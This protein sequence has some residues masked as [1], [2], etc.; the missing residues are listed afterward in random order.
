MSWQVYTEKR[1]AIAIGSGKI[2]HVLRRMELLALL[3][4][5]SSP[6]WNG[7]LFTWCFQ[8]IFFGLGMNISTMFLILLSAMVRW[9]KDD[10]SFVEIQERSKHP[11]KIKW[12]NTIPVFGICLCI[13]DITTMLFIVLQGGEF[14]YHEWLFQ[15]S[16][17]ATWVGILIIMRYESRYILTQNWVL[18]IWWFIK[19]FLDLP[20]LWTVC[21]SS[22]GWLSICLKESCSIFIEVIFGIMI[23]ILRIRNFSAITENRESNFLKHPLIFSKG[24]DSKFSSHDARTSNILSYL[25]FSWVGPMMDVGLKRQLNFDDLFRLPDEL[26]PVS[27]HSALQSYWVD[28]ERKLVGEPSLFRAICH[29]YGWPYLWIGILKVLNDGLGFM[30]PLL[31]NTLIRILQGDIGNGHPY[32]YYCAFGLGVV[33]VS[34]AFLGSHYSYLLSKLKL[35][36][37]ASIITIVYQKCL[38]ISLAERTTFS[39]GEIQTLM[40]V[41]AD[42]AVNICASFHD[43]WSLPLQMGVA[44]FLLYMQVKFAFLAGLAVIILLIP[45]NR[46]IAGKISTASQ[47]M[48][49]QKDERV[50]KIGELLMYIRTLKMYNW[51]NIFAARLMETRENEVKHLATRKYLDAWCVYFWAT[52]PILFSLFTFGVYVLLGYSLD[53]A[54]VFTSLSLFNMLISPLNSFPWVINGLIE[55]FI[56]LQRLGRFLSCTELNSN[57]G[58]IGALQVKRGGI[59]PSGNHNEKIVEDMQDISIKNAEYVWSNSQQECQTPV[60][61][62]ISVEIPKGLLTVVLGEVGAGKSSLLSAILGEM[63]M[64]KGEISKHGSVAY[65]PQAPWILSGTVRDNILFGNEYDGDRYTEVLA[66]CALDMDIC[67]MRG[68]D[69]AMIGEKGFNLSGGQRARVAL[70]RALYHDCDIYLLD[71]TLSAVDAHVASWLLQEAIQGSLMAHKTRILCT[72]NTQAVQMANMIIIMEKGTIKWAGSPTEFH[73]SFI[74]NSSE[75]I[76]N[77]FVS[78]VNANS[79]TCEDKSQSEILPVVER[80]GNMD[81]NSL[82]GNSEIFEEEARKEGTVQFDIYRNYAAFSGWTIVITILISTFL[83]QL[84]RNG[85]DFWLS[86]WVDSTPKGPHNQESTYLYLVVLTAIATCNS[87]FTLARAFSFTFGGLRA[88]LHVHNSLLNKVINAPISFFDR[89]PRGRILN[90]FSSDQYAID[91]SLP[92]ILNIV[93]ANFFSL[94]GIT[95]VLCLVQWT[96]LLLLVPLGYIYSKLQVYYRATSRELR[97]LDS[98]SRSPIYTSFTEAL[99]GASTIRAFTK[100]ALFTSQN[101]EHVTLNQRASYSELAA[102]V[103]LSIRLQL[104]AAFII[105]FI[106]IMAVVGRYKGLPISSGTTGLVGL[107]L[108]YAIPIISLLNDLL[109]SFTETEKEMISVERVQQYMDVFPEELEG[110]SCVDPNWPVEGLI[111]FNQV[112]LRYMPFLPPALRAVSFTINACEQV[113]IAGRTGAGKSSVL[114][115]IFRLTPIS[116]GKILIDNVDIS[117]VSLKELRSRLT[118]V[119]QTPFLFEGSLRENLDPFGNITDSTIWEVLQ[120][121]HIKD[122]VMTTGGLDTHVTE[123]GDCFSTGQRQLLCLARALLKSSKV[124]CLDECTANVD[125]QTTSLLKE[126]VATEC[127]GITV[128]TIAHRI[129][130]IANMDRVLIFDQGTIVEEGNPQILLEDGSSRFSSFA[131]ASFL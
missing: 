29:A 70:A 103:W 89:N 26:D 4:P 67:Y 48:M 74:P 118:V 125:P 69:L 62:Q 79:Q 96:F 37:R 81:L 7:Y 49:K 85:N 97:R 43:I 38:F 53:A 66:A 75:G 16:Q 129:S 91:D 87:L 6:V 13:L 128:I 39:S 52:T 59:F 78:I 109:T 98:V 10:Q 19:P 115:A 51:E 84:S 15:S 46:W 30:G 3:C 12:L 63:R 77:L 57:Q 65:V 131:R 120:K 9:R 55:A 94:F 40:S 113:G 22:E 20:R 14:V 72:H 124:L 28:E 5:H 99:D 23:L 27:C 121:C 112:T 44:L 127:K 130:T 92:F 71:D 32:G 60:L 64:I 114:N 25:M 36:L 90:R 83:M 8:N 56:S 54:T 119:P 110:H 50:R 108:S 47:L 34:R 58:G 76:N 100:Q 41:D 111:E 93:L 31:L 117:N 17:L 122:A 61:K 104:L 123:G 107:S 18:C 33:S 82:E 95:V 101:H 116:D 21:T 1:N 24:V 105:S 80:H 126:T 11:Q 42:R 2:L 73:S 35:R 88:A 102:S 45:V 106:S 86:Y 68:G